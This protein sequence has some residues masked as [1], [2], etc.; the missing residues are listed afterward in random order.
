MS[1]AD[2]FSVAIEHTRQFNLSVPPYQFESDRLWLDQKTLAVFP[3]V[4]RDGLKGLAVHDVALQCLAINY[5]LL[6]V[7]QS[8]LDCPVV[9][10]IG[11]IA[12]DTGNNMYEFDGWYLRGTPVELMLVRF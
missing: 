1:Y 9:Y 8:W 12:H 11:W 5:R 10:T 2:D 4:V 6:P 7:L 3:Y